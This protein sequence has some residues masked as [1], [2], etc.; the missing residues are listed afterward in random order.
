VLYCSERWT[1]DRR[2][3]QTTKYECSGN[4]NAYMSS[5]DTSGVT[6]ENKAR[7]FKR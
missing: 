1:V 3:E 4:E 6:G 7:V 5:Y 2:I